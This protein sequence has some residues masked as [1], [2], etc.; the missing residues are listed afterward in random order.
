MSISQEK[1]KE[2]ESKRRE[3]VLSVALN[4]FYK[5]GYKDTKIADIA[6]A[7]NMSKGLVYHYFE[8]KADILFAYT[9]ALN[10]CLDE[11]LAMPSAKAAI[12]EFGRRFLSPPNEHHPLRVYLTVFVRGE[13]NDSKY[14]NP[15]YQDM[16]ITYFGPLFEK[17]IKAGE[18]KQ[19]NAAEFGDFYW[20]Y[21]LGYLMDAIQ[22]KER[23]IPMPNVDA[24]ISL[25]ES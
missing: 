25:F 1:K 8:S 4:L 12:K 2:I 11:L 17:G 14:E 22:N 9:P 18:F 20:H 23:T 5:N 19:G 3:Q 6:K 10:N 7:A 15:V 16:G 13:L 24:F 21:L